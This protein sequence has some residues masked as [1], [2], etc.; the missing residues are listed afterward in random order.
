M[1]FPTPQRQH[2][3]KVGFDKYPE[4]ELMSSEEHNKWSA[5]QVTL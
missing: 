5:V 2:W 1:S 4:V 3:Q